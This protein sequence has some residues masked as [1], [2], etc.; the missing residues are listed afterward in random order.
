MKKIIALALSLT[1]VMSLF[2]ACGSKEASKDSS[3]KAAKTGLAVVTSLGKSA[4][5]GEKDGLA[6]V[7]S[8]VVAVLVGED[9]K[10]LKC[11]IDTQQTKVN[12][13]TEGA[14]LT[15]LDTAFQTK[16]E[17]KEGYNMKPVSSI[18][19]EWYEQ[20]DAFA[21]YVVGKTA[22]EVKDIA[23]NEGVP[24]DADLAATVT[25]KTQ[26]YMDAIVKAVANAQD[27]GAKTTDKLGLAVTTNIG[28]SKDATA[29][30]DGQ[31]QAYC[32]YA[33]VTVGADGKITSM[34]LDASQGTVKFSAEGKITSD[35]TA[36]VKTK[37]ELKEGYNMKAASGISK[38]WY[39]QANAYATYVVG[40][41]AAD[42]KGIAVTDGAPSGDDLKASVTVTVT[43]W[44]TATDKA[45]ANAR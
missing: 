38:E 28:K 37:Q 16:Q 40:K 1:L 10:I 8:V 14:L 30:T 41:T 23:L 13:S 43:D 6:Q 33:A 35:L 24:A 19:K 20:A 29:D 4:D 21:T 5:A 26:G 27:L 2:A 18:S 12:F 44:I 3:A 42:V 9:G 11:E 22:D 45:I 34:A 15:A 39:E 31:A 25:M 17:L 7:D 36:E 32:H